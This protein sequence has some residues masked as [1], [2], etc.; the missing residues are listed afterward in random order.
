MEHKEGA[1]LS[2]IATTIALI[3][4][5]FVAIGA[6]AGYF[7]LM[8]AADQG[9]LQAD[10]NMR[11]FLISQVVSSDP[12][13]WKF[14]GHAID[15]IISRKFHEEESDS[16]AVRDANGAVLYENG[17]SKLPWPVLTTIRPIYDS[18][19]VVG[20]I[21]L[22]HSIRHIFPF[23]GLVALISSMVGLGVFFAV[24]MYPMRALEQAW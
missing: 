7:Y 17:S 10:A 18:G 14:E 20:R 3:A 24:R 12:Q 23:T 2:R 13:L 21:E 9:R 19:H 15:G 8:M 1:L 4:A 6:P 22:R 16:R 11:S 5:L